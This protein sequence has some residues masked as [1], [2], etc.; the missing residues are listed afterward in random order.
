MGS[1]E[2]NDT[3]RCDVKTQARGCHC[4]VHPHEFVPEVTRC[5]ISSSRTVDTK[6]DRPNPTS[7]CA[8]LCQHL[9]RETCRIGQCLASAESV[10]EHRPTMIDRWHMPVHPQTVIDPERGTTLR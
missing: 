9:R 10:G 1:F 3:Y 4:D 5:R 2:L 7:R 6:L 8:V